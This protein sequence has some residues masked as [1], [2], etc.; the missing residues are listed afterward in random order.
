MIGLMLPSQRPQ[1]FEPDLRVRIVGKAQSGRWHKDWAERVAKRLKVG[2]LA[3]R[4]D[5]SHFDPMTQPVW[6]LAMVIAWIVWRTP[7]DVRENW[8]AYRVECWDW[9]HRPHFIPPPLGSEEHRRDEW[10]QTGKSS[11]GLVTLES[12]SLMK[13]RADEALSD[14]TADNEK[15]KLVTVRDAWA[16]L[17]DRAAGGSLVV[18]AIQKDDRRP[19]EIPAREWAYLEHIS[20]WP[21]DDDGLDFDHGIDSH[22]PQYRDMTFRRDEVCRLWPRHPERKQTIAGERGCQSWLEDEMRQSTDSRPKSKGK[23][24]AEGRRRFNVAERAFERAWSN[25]IAATGAAA[26]SNAGRPSKKSSH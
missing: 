25:A 6:T 24:K 13:L 20:S 5:P 16:E 2:P 8:N 9:Q 1:D 4:P 22:N 18:T 21:L 14:A 3:G 11:W 26:W 19:V 17:R 10:R 12:A 15:R 7:D 23:Y